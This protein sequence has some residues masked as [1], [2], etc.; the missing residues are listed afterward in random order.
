PAPAEPSRRARRAAVR[1]PEPR[2]HGVA[3]PLARRSGR[4]LAAEADPAAAPLP[5]RPPDRAA[6]DARPGPAYGLGDGRARP[7]RPP[8]RAPPRADAVRRQPVDAGA[9]HGL[10]A[11]HA[12]TRDARR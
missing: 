9:G 1:G 5:R 12:W 8:V 4:R 6:P 7:R 10:P 2:R 3:R 11:P